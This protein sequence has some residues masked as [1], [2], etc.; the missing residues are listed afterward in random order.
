MTLIAV[1]IALVVERSLSHVLHWR[2]PHWFDRYYPWAEERFIVGRGLAG[3]AGALLALFVPVLPVGLAA[4]LMHDELRGLFWIGFAAMVLVFSF[5]PRDLADEVDA[6]CG[7]EARGASDEARAAAEILVEQDAAQRWQQR[8]SAVEDAVLVQANNRVFGVLLWFMILGPAGAW[9]FRVSDLLRRAAIARLR[10]AG[11]D[12]S[13]ARVAAGVL[14]QI[15]GVLAWL[16]ARLLAGSY[17]IAGT[18]D[19][20]SAGW[21]AFRADLPRHFFDANDHL[22]VYVGRGAIGAQEGGLPGA[23]AMAAMR[24]VR[25]SF[26]LW[27]T[28]VS[29]LTLL[30]WVA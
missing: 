10:D 7:A 24:L 25:R 4:T 23:P 28:L 19:D 12:E 15:H 8:A 5:G 14:Q 21:R 27:L 16:P 2:E 17:L 11:S 30:A 9:A 22:L 6:Y 29:I 18:F 3:P 1:V 26:I 20:A 13:H